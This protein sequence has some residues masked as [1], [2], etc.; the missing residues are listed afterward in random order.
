[1]HIKGWLRRIGGKQD[2]DVG[3]VGSEVSIVSY[4]VTDPQGN[5]LG[6]GRAEVNA[7]GGYD[8]VFTVPEKTILG[9]AQMY[10]QAEGSL[11]SL[12]GS[13]YYHN[14]QIQEFRRPEFE[15]NA[16]NEIPG[17]YFAGGHAT[18]AV[19]AK[20]YAGGPLP[21]AEVT[22][23]VTSS[24]SHY[25]PPNWPD[26]TFGTW[27]PWWW[28]YE[29][30]RSEET[31]VEYSGGPTRTYS[32]VTDAA[33]E[34]YL[35]LDFNEYT[36]PRPFSVLAQATVMDVNRQAWSSMTSLLVHPAN[37]Y[38]GMRSERYFVERG[39]PL[40]VDVIV[41]DLDGNP[42][43]DRPI[44]VRA[45]RLEWKYRGE[46]WSEEEAD[47]QE[48]KLGSTVEPVTCTFET[49]L[50]GRYMIT[51]SVTDELGRANQSQFTRWVSGGQQRPARQVEQEQLTL[52]P[53]KESYQPGDVAHIL[54]Q[55]PFSPAEGLLTV[56][57][58][59]IVYLQRFRIEQ[60]SITLDVPIEEKSSQ[61]ECPGDAVAQQP[62]R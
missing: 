7:L 37:L 59:G 57:R 9:Y 25:A 31:F 3:L 38:I 23:Q 2:G 62:P 44:L 45:A 28:I 54:V 10:M 61:P 34:H 12:D 20:Y 30:I 29:P 43:A 8:F 26:F 15:V 22:W 39:T 19:E 1:V 42:V 47:V 40:K 14:F 18:V 53:D 17:P 24:P 50:G 55:A 35:R 56:G 51:A 41:T 6:G 5:D 4:Q 13:Q 36:E 21:N 60:N 48:C 32:G 52:I 58:S 33:G 46:N 11:A 49:P 16:R 27:Q